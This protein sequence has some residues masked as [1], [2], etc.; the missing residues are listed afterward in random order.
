MIQQN[1]RPLAV[2]YGYRSSGNVINFIGRDDVVTLGGVGSRIQKILCCCNGLNTVRDIIKELSPMSPKEIRRLLTV[3]ESEGIVKDSREL[4]QGFHA[5]SSNPPIFSRDLG[6]DEIMAIVNSPRLRHR[7]GLVVKKM[8]PGASTLLKTIRA[9]QST[10]S[11]K[12][13]QIKS[14]QLAGILEATYSIGKNGHW[15]V[16]S[17]GGLYP[18]DLYLIVLNDQQVI[19]SGIYRWNP[20]S[21]T[22]TAMS[23]K[24]PQVWTSKVFNAKTLLDGAACILCIAANLKRS[25]A[26]YGNRG[27]RLALLEAGHAAQNTY[28]FCAEQG[29][30]VVECCGF[31]DK[32][33][34]SRLGLAS[35]DEVVLTTLV[36]GKVGSEGCADVTSDQKTSETANRLFQSLV[37]EG[38]PIVGIET[39]KTEVEGYSM[40]LWAATATYS[41]GREGNSAFSTGFTSSEA[42]VKALAEGF[43]RYALEQNN[44]EV[45]ESAEKLGDPFLDP[46]NFV[47]LSPTQLKKLKEIQPFDPK[48]KIGWVSGMRVVGGEKVWVPT[49]L[50]YYAAAKASLRAG[51][52]YRASSSG[53]AA[54][55]DAQVAVDSAIYELIER[56]ALSVKWYSKRRVYSIAH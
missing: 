12:P 16:A 5:D 1:S 19:P 45:N 46:R 38:K 13:G 28:L 36:L 9:R 50:V 6:H 40:P 14:R 47:P 53:V 22:L 27:Y 56:D 39:L 15:S 20:E 32:A 3:C 23:G 34:E 30:G 37:G 54:H 43:E 4:H 31:D 2:L 52:C 41:S 8:T 51:I 7:D 29:I 18:L 55:F 35:P 24:N 21:G 25:V 33:L 42:V 26:K 49:D 48:M 17:G 11:F 10:R 44:S